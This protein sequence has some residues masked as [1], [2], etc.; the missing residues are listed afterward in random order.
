MGPAGYARQSGQLGES[1]SNKEN[2]TSK[3]K[4]KR[5]GKGKIPLPKPRTV[6][7]S[8]KFALLPRG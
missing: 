7:L 8:I 3:E 1:H 6:H 5:R 2:P 4:G